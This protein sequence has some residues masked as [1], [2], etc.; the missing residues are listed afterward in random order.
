MVVT[1]FGCGFQQWDS[2]GSPRVRR[3]VTVK[4]GA[5]HSFVVLIAQ[6]RVLAGYVDVAQAPIQQRAAVD[7]GG[8]AARPSAAFNRAA[9]KNG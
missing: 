4:L 9:K 7:R 3:L 8:A 1:C 2:R 5:P 6:A